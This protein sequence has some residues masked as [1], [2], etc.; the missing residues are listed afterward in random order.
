MKS[1]ILVCDAAR[2]TI[3]T[4]DDLET[5]W[6]RLE[7]L[8]HADSRKKSSELSPTEPGGAQKSKGS[9]RHTTFEAHTTPHEAEARHFAVELGERLNQGA[10]RRAFEQLVIAAPPQF[11]GLLRQHLHGDTAKRIR[12]AIDKDYTALAER[13]L[14]LRIVESLRNETE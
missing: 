10:S 14:K 8:S 9:S 11:L 13:E 7:E 4:A 6:Q 12:A 3:F 1:W 2:A 5:Q